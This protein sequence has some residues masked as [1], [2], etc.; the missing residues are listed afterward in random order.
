MIKIDN[1]AAVFVPKLS[2]I[3]FDVTHLRT[4]PGMNWKGRGL[5]FIPCDVYD[6]KRVFAQALSG[7]FMVTKWSFGDA[8]L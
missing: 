6:V 3:S 2:S 5:V 4:N 1:C 8:L 7:F